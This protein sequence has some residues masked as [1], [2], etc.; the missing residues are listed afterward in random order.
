V[1]S[2]HV[3]L[4]VKS[5][6]GAFRRGGLPW[7]SKAFP[8]NVA[9]RLRNAASILRYLEPSRRMRRYPNQHTLR[10]YLDKNVAVTFDCSSRFLQRA[11][12]HRIHRGRK[13]NNYFT[14]FL[15]DCLSQLSEPFGN[16]GDDSIV[17]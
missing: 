1:H 16:H 13:P 5:L 14:R 10:N 2:V 3:F 4:A 15:L 7:R 12:L 11:E 17:A 9:A 6:G 8:G